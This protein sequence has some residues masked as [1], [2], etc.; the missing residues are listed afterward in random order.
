MY[1]C[2]CYELKKNVKVWY[3]RRYMSR[4]ARKFLENIILIQ[5]KIKI[6]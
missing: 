2:G 1:R 3:H 6:S 5:R 4:N